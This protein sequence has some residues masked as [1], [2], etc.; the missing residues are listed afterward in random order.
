MNKLLIAAAVT[1]G[2]AAPTVAEAKVTRHEL[3]RDV[4]DVHQERHDVKRALKSGNPARIKAEKRELHG[5]KQELRE[6]LRDLKH[7]RRH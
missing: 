2:L 5:A 6:D 3:H 1:L 7:Q 4:R